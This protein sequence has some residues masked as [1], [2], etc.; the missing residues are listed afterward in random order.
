MIRR[1][2]SAAEQA[3]ILGETVGPYRILGALGDGRLGQLYVAEQSEAR[4]APQVVVLRHVRSELAGSSRF[5]A[6]FQEAV[7][8]ATRCEHPNLVGVFELFDLDSKSADGRCFLSMEYLP[9][10]TV[11]SILLRCSRGDAMPPDIAAYVV[12]QA[13]AGLQCWRDVHEAS[14]LS[15]AVADSEV[16]PSDV[17]VTHHGTV[18]WL[19]GGLR[20]LADEAAASDTDGWMSAEVPRPVGDDRAPAKLETGDQTQRGGDV[21]SLGRLLWTC[22]AG[23]RPSAGAATFGA[24]A[25]FAELSPLPAGV[26][27]ALRSV[28][29]RALSVDSPERFESPRA[30]ADELDRYLLLHPSRPT[31]RQLRR[32]LE[33]LFGADRALL[34]MRVARGRDVQA[35]LAH[36]GAALPI[37]GPAKSFRAFS[38]PRPRELWLTRHATFSQFGRAS[39]APP[40]SFDRAVGSAPDGFSRVS[41]IP[42]QHPSAGADA[43]PSTLGSAELPA[44]SQARERSSRTAWAVV[45]LVACAGLALAALMLVLQ[46]HD[47]PRLGAPA[48]GAA[49][50]DVSPGVSVRSTPEGAAVFIDGEPTGLSTPVVVRGLAAGRMVRVRVEKAGFQSREQSIEV[51][52]GSVAERMFELSASTGQV[53]FIG[54]PAEARAYVDDG[55]VV[56]QGG[57]ALELSVGSHTVRV[58]TAS[59]LLFSGTVD[60]VPGEQTVRMGGDRGP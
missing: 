53:H 19:A 36:L 2:H 42:F 30:M 38:M 9:G 43:P 29:K 25:S 7:R 52:P 15:S 41:V 47:A 17:F 18:K 27:D 32:W 56:V 57:A 58:E 54:V 10:E 60:V 33:R 50:A 24:P 44:R 8:V 51:L 16:R 59:E 40:R 3:P 55:A 28:V 22:L 20:S 5:R 1:T 26:P 39:I 45:T 11:E 48:P 23:K 46:P 6:R 21:S 35:A 4:G 12:K 37:D 31:P 13:A 14:P 34:Q 49:P